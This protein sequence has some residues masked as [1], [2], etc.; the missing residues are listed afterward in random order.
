MKVKNGA[1][2]RRLGRKILGAARKRNRIAVFA[3]ALTTLLFTSIFTV[4][5]SLNKSY[6]LFQF[7]QIGG[8]NHGTF[9]HVDEEEAAAISSSKR[10]KQTG[11]RRMAGISADGVFGKVPAEVSYMDANEAKWSFAE[12]ET[13]RMPEKGNEIAMDTG[14][15]KLLG[16]E[17]ELGEEVPLPG[18]WETG[19]RSRIKR[20]IRSRSWASGSTMT[21]SR[22]IL[23]MFRRNTQSRWSRKPSERARSRFGGT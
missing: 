16:A 15:L 19:R 8:C 5:M 7:R 14:A 9:K 3:I 18:R 13:G 20:P 22:Y 17:P 12:P 2:I 11:E 23:S 1:C 4:G 10:V 21:L 6:E